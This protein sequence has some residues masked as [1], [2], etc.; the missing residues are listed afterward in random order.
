MYESSWIFNV[1]VY[2]IDNKLVLMLY[3]IGALLYIFLSEK[4]IPWERL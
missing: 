3:K 1:D 2:G 4:D